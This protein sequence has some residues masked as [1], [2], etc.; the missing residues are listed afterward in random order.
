MFG[1]Q[2][3]GN[4]NLDPIKSTNY[5]LSFEWYFAPESALVLGGFYKDVSTFIA[6]QFD[7]VAAPRDGNTASNGNI[8]KQT[9]RDGVNLLTT[10]NALGQATTLTYDER[11]NLTSVADPLG[12]VQ[13]Y[14]YDAHGNV[15]TSTDA[16]GNTTTSSFDY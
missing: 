4:P 5:D 1:G 10:T 3:N 7:L 16:A 14:T 6:N 13:R 12:H 9:K 15:V 8:Y 2:Q 11:G